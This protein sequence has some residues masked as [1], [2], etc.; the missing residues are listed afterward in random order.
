MPHAGFIR[1]CGLALIAAGALTLIVNALAT[2]MMPRG[3][4]LSATAASTAFLIRQ[5]LAA[6]AALLL[7]LGATGL[8]V[9]QADRMRRLGALAFAMAFAGS[10]MLFAVEWTQL[11]EV[12]D[13]A[14]RAPDTLDRLDAGGIGLDDIGAMTALAVLVIGWISLAAVTM[15]AGIMPRRAALLV[16]AGLFATPFLSAVL[17]PV[18]A[19]AIGNALLGAGWIWLGSATLYSV[20]VRS[21][22]SSP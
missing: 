1:W 2:P 13:L 4:A 11:F 6:G 17:S 22:R 15:R 12:R 20:A 21:L 16:V 14:R 10:V 9:R 3:G 7:A 5:S 19:A 8:Y 18:A